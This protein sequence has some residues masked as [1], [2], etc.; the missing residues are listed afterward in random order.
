MEI[1]FI[2]FQK[3]WYV[4]L[5]PIYS[6][7]TDLFQNFCDK[8]YISGITKF[9]VYFMLTLVNMLEHLFYPK[10]AVTTKNILKQICK[11]IELLKLFFFAVSFLMH[12]FKFIV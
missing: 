6:Y 2:Y 4:I 10:L 8:K 3:Y 7:T 5:Y 12:P 11:S 9:L 1:F